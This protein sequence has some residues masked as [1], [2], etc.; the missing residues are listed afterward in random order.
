M[1][2]VE[3][4]PTTSNSKK[5]TMNE[6]IALKQ[7]D[8]QQGGTVAKLLESSDQETE[9]LKKQDKNSS[10][11]ENGTASDHK[12]DDNDPLDSNNDEDKGSNGKKLASKVWN[13]SN[14]NI[15]KPKK[16]KDGEEV[17][18][19]VNTV[20]W[21]TP[22]EAKHYSPNANALSPQLFQQFPPSPSTPPS[23]A[24]GS[25]VPTTTVTPTLSE[26]Q[27]QSPPPSSQQQ[28]SEP[29]QILQPQQV[30]PQ[31]IPP[32]SQT[33]IQT[34][35][36]KTSSTSLGVT[37]VN[38]GGS[39]NSNGTGTV[40]M[41]TGSGTSTG[42]K[43]NTSGGNNYGSNNSHQQKKKMN[44][45]PMKDINLITTTSKSKIGA[46][47]PRTEKP[48]RD[49]G[50]VDRGRGGKRNLINDRPKEESAS[51][52]ATSTKPVQD[53]PVEIPPQ[54]EQINGLKGKEEV[55]QDQNNRN[56][57]NSIDK[58]PAAIENRGLS[59]GDDRG[60][61]GIRR[62]GRANFAN[63]RQPNYRRSGNSNRGRGYNNGYMRG[64]FMGPPVVPIYAPNIPFEGGSHQE[65]VTRQIEYYFS[66]DNLCKDIY[67]RKNMDNEGY[68]AISMIANFNRLKVLTSDLK[69][70][71]ECMRSSNF[72][73]V[74]GDY[75]RRKEGWH[76]FLIPANSSIDTIITGKANPAENVHVDKPIVVAKG[77]ENKASISN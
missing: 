37:S 77:E 41:S 65:M 22:G 56:A 62:G 44:W 3:N 34:V 46:A 15:K 42:N 10:L 13:N 14:N 19:S 11:A 8:G 29:Q 74:K 21:P 6:E 70:I 60:R 4:S 31:Q 36:P 50:R 47:D 76:T 54:K 9:L 30:P 51:V 55:P 7:S 45:K 24:T 39:G 2:Q 58:A 17:S 16:N 75:I 40:G 18:P 48:R 57:A 52:T 66:T 68:V 26:S 71:T 28:L 25:V 1:Q 32:L 35:V 67:L 23:I 49:G 73:E 43:S 27:T 5:L 33:A 20:D 63:N 69:L 64:V 53:L 59:N 38:S 61:G 72:L 12:N